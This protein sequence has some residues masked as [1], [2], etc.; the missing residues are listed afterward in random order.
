MKAN[1]KKKIVAGR[2]E[3]DLVNSEKGKKNVFILQHA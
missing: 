3:R 2:L 1:D